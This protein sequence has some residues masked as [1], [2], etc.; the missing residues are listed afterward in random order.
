MIAARSLLL[1]CVMLLLLLLACVMLLLLQGPLS[2][3]GLIFVLKSGSTGQNTKWLKVT[4]RVADRSTC[5]MLCMSRQHDAHL[6]C[7]T[8]CAVHM[9]YTTV[10]VCVCGLA[11]RIPDRQTNLQPQGSWCGLMCN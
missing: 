6:L 8:T 1:A 11:S 2:E 7:D 5:R 4:M 9:P 3:G 10:C